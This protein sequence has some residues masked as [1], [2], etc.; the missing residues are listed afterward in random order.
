MIDRR[1]VIPVCLVIL[2]TLYFSTQ[3]ASL[4]FAESTRLIFNATQSS[5]GFP[6]KNDTD[7][8]YLVKGSV[9][10]MKDN[11]PGG[12][13]SHF[14]VLPELIRIDPGQHQMLRVVLIAGELP[15]DRESVFFVNGHFIPASQRP[16]G[17][18]S[19]LNL[20]FSI[21]VKLF[22]RPKGL[23]DMMAIK[24]IAPQVSFS[25]ND[26]ELTAYNSSP[27]WLTFQTLRYGDAPVNSDD[28]RKMVPPFGQETYFVSP[29]DLNN[30]IVE[31]SLVDE[32]GNGTIITTR[33]LISE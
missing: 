26:H 9:F 12:G 21:N 16:T 25:V 13:S 11:R 33:K 31:W 27:Y 15:Q 8:H 6:V 17:S 14:W 4:T 24:K 32:F 1:T 23:V 30:Q 29:S 19:P 20:S 22:Y 10:E 2:P 5:V 18:D 7:L 28:I 3:A